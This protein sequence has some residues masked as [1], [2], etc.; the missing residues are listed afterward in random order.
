MQPRKLSLLSSKQLVYSKY[1]VWHL[2]YC[3]ANANLYIY[4]Y[5]RQVK[6]DVANIMTEKNKA[7]NLP[8]THSKWKWNQEYCSHMVK[9]HHIS[10]LSTILWNQPDQLW[11]CLERSLC[12]LSEC[13]TLMLGYK[14]QGQ[15][16]IINLHSPEQEIALLHSS[17]W[18]RPMDSGKNYIWTQW[19]T[20]IPKI[21]WISILI[22]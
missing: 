8:K 2:Q 10:I 7:S 20:P 4:E 16:R 21:L 19:Y 18:N 11:C 22:P 14:S 3:Y 15:Q 5:F 6:K 13:S 17:S 9:N 1:S 12:Y